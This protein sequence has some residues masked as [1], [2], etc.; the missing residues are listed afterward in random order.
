MSA[1]AGSGLPRISVSRSAG[2]ARALPMYLSTLPDELRRPYPGARGALTPPPLS[3]SSGPL[4]MTFLCPQRGSAWDE[5]ETAPARRI[6][7][8]KLWLTQVI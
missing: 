3:C 1:F 7:V 6:L 2:S 4:D 5:A 8:A